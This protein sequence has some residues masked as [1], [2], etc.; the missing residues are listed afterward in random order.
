MLSRRI[1]LLVD[2]YNSRRYHE[3]LG[4]LTAGA[5]NLVHP[6]IVSKIA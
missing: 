4:N 2:H 1:N 5:F 6:K 3:A